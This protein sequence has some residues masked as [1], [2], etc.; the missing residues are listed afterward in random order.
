[1][2]ATSSCLMAALAG[3]NLIHD[4]GLLGGA[5]VVMPEMIV[6]TDEI[7]AMLRHLLGEVQVDDESLSLDLFSEVAHRG[8]FLTHPYTL[9]HL[10]D[11]W[12]PALL[13]RG[14]DKAWAPGVS[15]TFE[16]RVNARTRRIIETHRP[17]LL[18]AAAAAEIDRI[19]AAA[20]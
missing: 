9:A 8:D 18:D 2:E 6:A 7:V 15:P 17:P 5:T 19:L 10:R 20:R 16:Q 4:I 13:Y 14:G 3:A 11:V 1:M 12:Y